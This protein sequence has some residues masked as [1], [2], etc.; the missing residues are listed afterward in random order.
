MP[1][2]PNK[3]FTVVSQAAPS[4]DAAPAAAG[5]P[6]PVPDT[7]ISPEEFGQKPTAPSAK[8]Y[9]ID[10][11]VL[12]QIRYPADK[13]NEKQISDDLNVKREVA[14]RIAEGYP[15]Y[16]ATEAWVKAK[17]PEDGLA[18]LYDWA[19][20]NPRQF[21]GEGAIL[22]GQ[23]FGATR[24]AGARGMAQEVGAAL[25]RGGIG[26]AS[27]VIGGAIKG[28]MPTAGKVAKTAILTAPGLT[29]TAGRPP[30]E[31][32]ANVLKL[33]GAG[34][35]GETAKQA[36]EGK[37]YN[38]RKIEEE[39]MAGGLS[40]IG[41]HLTDTGA[42]AAA[43]WSRFRQEAPLVRTLEMA[44]RE[45]LL[46]D[47]S[48]LPW[49]G[50]KTAVGTIAS[51]G[52]SLMQDAFSKVNQRT[53][54]DR[55]TNFFSVPDLVE[56]L[57][58]RR[59][60]YNDV[61]RRVGQLSPAANAAQQ[62]WQAGMEAWTDNS[63]IAATAESARAR[64]AARVDARTAIADANTAFAEMVREA[65]AAGN[66]GLTNDLRNARVRLAQIHATSEA[67]NPATGNIDGRIIG[68]A[69][70]A[71]PQYFTDVLETIGR[72]GA[73][74]PQVVQDPLMIGNRYRNLMMRGTM[75]SVGG[76]VGYAVSAMTG[77]PTTKTVTTGVVAGSAIP[78][79]AQQIMGSQ[80][81][82]SQML[83]PR[84][85]I[86]TPDLQAMLARFGVQNAAPSGLNVERFLQD[87][88]RKIQPAK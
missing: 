49:A 85:A 83:N 84:Y 13:W 36:L 19:A 21:V 75:G 38:V 73:A 10:D 45:G 55:L 74:M 18:A 77:L 57:N 59:D 65:N 82:Q 71:S 1:F 67:V 70:K 54:K 20:A 24:G 37:G 66:P 26:A 81:V 62:R 12:G 68:E 29:S 31:I 23:V 53:M 5:L 72:L 47:V 51:G 27:E 86:N 50:A 88:Q 79:F 7:P 11:P 17:T 64:A 52:Q 32:A 25:T 58:A 69:Y 43:A 41:M 56:G 2:D 80:A 46:V 78:T 14:K 60:Y 34:M 28:E 3:P 76:T 63:R 30:E 6:I 40:A 42:R 15:Q 16:L 48:S 4:A 35:A 44:N 9:V 22:V 61:Y 33:T 8:T 39:G 87:V